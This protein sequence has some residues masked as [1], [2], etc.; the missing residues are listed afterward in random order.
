V[1][2]NLRVVSPRTMQHH[3]AP[4]GKTFFFQWTDKKIGM[5]VNYYKSDTPVISTYVFLLHVTLI[6]IADKESP[7]S[8]T[9][10]CV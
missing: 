4:S 1:R 9:S 7:S 2:L 8:T 6:Y 5:T 3:D 10:D